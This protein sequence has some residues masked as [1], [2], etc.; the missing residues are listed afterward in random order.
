[1]TNENA[2]ML[3]K[4]VFPDEKTIV[5]T[6]RI[7]TQICQY[8]FLFPFFVNLR[9]LLLFYNG[10][11]NS[12]VAKKMTKTVMYDEIELKS[13]K[14]IT[15]SMGIDDCAENLDEHDWGDK[16]NI[17]YYESENYLYINWFC[18]KCGAQIERHYKLPDIPKPRTDEVVE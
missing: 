11:K 6:L 1:M 2:I 14:E 3:T 4:S 7:I 8:R 5:K 17:K 15:Q 16:P 13:D 9:S 18:I 10:L 12:E